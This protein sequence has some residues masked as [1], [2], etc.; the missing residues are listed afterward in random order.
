M[1]GELAALGTAISWTV[2]AVLYRR[3]LSNTKPLQANI[4]RLGCT[5]LVLMGFIALI[6]KLSI[7]LS[8]PVYSVV[9]SALS[10]LI[11][12]GL[13]DTLYMVSLKQIGVSRAVPISCTYPLFSLIVALVI[14]P[15]TVAFEVI[16][17][18]V[19]I[20]FG[21]WLLTREPESSEGKAQKSFRIRGGLFA[22]G[23]AVF[24][25]LSIAMINSAVTLPETGTL[26]SALVLNTIRVLSVAIFLLTSTPLTDRK[27]SFAKTQRKSLALLTLGGLVALGL[28]W[29]LLTY[30]F[31]YIPE[32]QAVP[33]SSTTPLFAVVSGMIF[34]KERITVRNVAGTI[35]I[36]LGVFLLFMF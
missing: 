9:L 28:G 6:G 13:G 7:F 4:V 5:S 27:F 15:K 17:A 22:L 1:L 16:V 36:V 24:W 34:L 18:A 10:G 26:D 8:L 33:I 23:A 11:G 21:I 20:V 25:A 2:S 19:A 30:S 31:L 3:A 32:A 14:Q 35:I 12:L 29:F